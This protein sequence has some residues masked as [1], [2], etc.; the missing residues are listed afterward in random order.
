MISERLFSSNILQSMD[1]I[2]SLIPGR[3]SVKTERNVSFVQAVGF[4]VT[5]KIKGT[6]N[7]GFHSNIMSSFI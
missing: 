6:S 2:L 7:T 4:W 1:Q 3:N 5:S